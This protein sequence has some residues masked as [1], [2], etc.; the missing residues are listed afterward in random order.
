MKRMHFLA[1]LPLILAAM[2]AVSCKNETLP[3]SGGDEKNSGAPYD[4]TSSV[5]EGAM[6]APGGLYGGQGGYQGGEPGVLT[7]GEWND[8]AHWDFWSQLWQSQN[9]ANDL[10]VWKF[11]TSHRVAVS[12]AVHEEGTDV[13]GPGQNV[14]VELWCGDQ[15]LWKARTN[16]YGQANCWPGL[17]AE[18]PEGTL[19]LKVAGQSAEAK[20]STAEEVVWNEFLLNENPATAAADIAFIVDATGSMTDEID[21]LKEDLL[22][23]LGTVREGRQY[24][25]IRTGAVFY[26]DEGDEYVTRTDDFTADVSQT[27]AFIRQQQADGGGDLPEAV[28]TALEMTLQ[29]LN[30]NTSAYTRLAFLLLDAPAH[31]DRPAVIESLHKSIS[32]FAGMGIRIIP[33]V[34]STSD[35]STEFMCRE[36]AI[37]TGGTYVFIT[38]DS[39]IGD[40]HLEPTVGE[41]KVEKL[42]ELLIRLIKENI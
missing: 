34:A 31:G 19:T 6:D 37:I 33:V 3:M 4:H 41:F 38:G 10:H 15:C 40:S 26:R 30:W 7:A 1:A 25:E 17:Y 35:K 12:V 39:G 14:P 21:F 24:V 13:V 28:H 8:L 27:M 36:F 29:K 5:M 22:S 23:I 11:N 16:C 9:Y 20:V 18:M 32:T 2:V 42:N